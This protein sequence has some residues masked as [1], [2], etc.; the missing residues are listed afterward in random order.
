MYTGID[1]N[2]VIS[3]GKECLL[4]HNFP[5]KY[6]L[7][8]IMSTARLFNVPLQVYVLV[9]CYKIL[10][11]R[12][13]IHLRAWVRSGEE[14][15]DQSVFSE[16]Q[17]SQGSA[18]HS[19]SSSPTLFCLV[20]GDVVKLG[21]VWV[22]SERKL[23]LQCTKTFNKMMCFGFWEQFGEKINTGVTVR[24]PHT[25]RHMMCVCIINMNTNF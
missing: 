8:I 22:S 21:Q 7:F 14:V 23:K 17:V 25:V 15:W 4:S 24:Y 12:V 1:L 2:H 11:G 20:H 6:L 5:C 19:T 10:P 13:C 18:G 3:E 9:C 16:G